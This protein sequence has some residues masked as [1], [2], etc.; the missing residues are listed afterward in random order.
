[1]RF[2]LLN[3]TNTDWVTEEDLTSFMLFDQFWYN[4]TEEIFKRYA[5]NIDFCDSNG[6]IY[7]VTYRIYPTSW[8]RNAFKFLPMVYKC[9][10]KFRKTGMQIPLVDL[11]H[12]MLERIKSLDKSEFQ[13]KWITMVENAK[14]HADI[15]DGRVD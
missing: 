3:I 14:T 12:F 9:T 13:H 1:M 15:I 11:R 5:L 7:Q 8:L 2:P 6:E 4:T 10:L